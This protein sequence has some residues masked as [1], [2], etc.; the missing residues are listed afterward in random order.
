MVRLPPPG[1][2]WSASRT[3]RVGEILPTEVPAGQVVA[4]QPDALQV[5]R[6][7]AS[8]GR[9]LRL[10]EPRD[11]VSPNEAPVT[12]APVRLALVSVEESRCASVRSAPAR[13]ALV[14]VE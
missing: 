4:P 12:T 8:G 2:H 7:I 6:L 5:L 14:S 10:G 11:V 9:E 13:L 3:D 1:W